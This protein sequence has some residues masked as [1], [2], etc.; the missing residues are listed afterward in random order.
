M[1][2]HNGTK[3]VMDGLHATSLTILWKKDFKNVHFIPCVLTT[4]LS[5]HILSLHSGLLTVGSLKNYPPT[6]LRQASLNLQNIELKASEH[7][8]SSETKPALYML[9]TMLP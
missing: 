8:W 2:D 5:K 7:E 1:Y 6:C 4:Y 3:N 9:H